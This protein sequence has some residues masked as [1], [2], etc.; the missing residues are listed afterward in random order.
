MGLDVLVVGLEQAGNASGQ[1]PARRLYMAYPYRGN[2]WLGVNLALMPWTASV[3]VFE[4]WYVWAEVVAAEIESSTGLRT[5]RLISSIYFVFL[6]RAFAA[7][8]LHLG[9]DRRYTRHVER[10][11]HPDDAR[12]DGEVESTC[13][14]DNENVMLCWEMTL[15]WA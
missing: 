4:E 9:Q 13:E 15:P 5:D 11:V 12:M 8:S 14:E 1:A 6:F 3:L 10:G 7:L 2:L